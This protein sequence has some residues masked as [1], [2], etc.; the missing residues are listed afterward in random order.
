NL[1]EP[2]RSA[3]RNF[4]RQALHAHRLELTHPATGQ[5]LSFETPMPEDLREL[6]TVLRSISR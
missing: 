2:A 6:L 3:C 1:Q 5:I 4:P